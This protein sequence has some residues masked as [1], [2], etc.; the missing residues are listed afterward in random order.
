MTTEAAFN[1]MNIIIDIKSGI[2]KI[3]PQVR[4]AAEG[5]VSNM[6]LNLV[7]TKLI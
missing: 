5:T 2:Q 1:L 7:I 6:R 3:Y 4:K